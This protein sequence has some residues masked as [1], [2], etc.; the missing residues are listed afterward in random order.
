MSILDLMVKSALQKKKAKIF[1]SH[2]LYSK[3]IAKYL[4]RK[5]SSTIKFS[6]FKY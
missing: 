4:V 5:P 3:R 1:K 6:N 2:E